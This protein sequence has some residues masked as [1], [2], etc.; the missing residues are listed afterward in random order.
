MM[1]AVLVTR[2]VLAVMMTAL[3]EVVLV[4]M[5]GHRSILPRGSTPPRSV[6]N[7]RRLLSSS[8]AGGGA[9]PPPARTREIV[10]FGWGTMRM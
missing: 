8:G 6:T 9:D 2:P 5:S 7:R 4:V 1:M 3:V 10:Y